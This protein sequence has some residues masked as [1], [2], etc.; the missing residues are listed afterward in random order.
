ML[1]LEL[2]GISFSWSS[3]LIQWGSRNS[4]EAVGEMVKTDPG[5]GLRSNMIMQIHQGQSKPCLDAGSLQ[6]VAE[7]CQ[8]GKGHDQSKHFWSLNSSRNHLPLRLYKRLR[9]GNPQTFWT[10]GIGMT[11]HL[12]LIS[13]RQLWNTWFCELVTNSSSNNLCGEL[14]C[15]AGE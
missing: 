3:Y 15:H 13:A 12:L 5:D 9:E 7:N 4:K 2:F 14:I 10:W 8:L 6:W 1:L 11:H